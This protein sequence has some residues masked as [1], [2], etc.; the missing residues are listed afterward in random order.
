MTRFMGNYIVQRFEVAALLTH[1]FASGERVELSSDDPHDVACLFKRAL[2]HM[3]KAK[4][5]ARTLPLKPAARTLPLKPARSALAAR[6]SHPPR[7]ACS[8]PHRCA[9]ARARTQAP[10]RAPALCVQPA[11][12]RASALPMEVPQAT[13]LLPDSLFADVPLTT[14]EPSGLADRLGRCALQHAA[15]Y[16]VG[17]GMYWLRGRRPMWRARLGPMWRARLGPMWRAR[18]GPMWRARLGPTQW[19]RL[20]AT[21]SYLHAVVSH[22]RANSMG[23][24]AVAVCAAPNLVAHWPAERLAQQAPAAAAAA[25]NNR[26][27]IPETKQRRPIRPCAL[28]SHSRHSAVGTPSTESTQ[29]TSRP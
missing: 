18:L 16:R 1:R 19:R 25:N 26:A 9:R 6:G 28:P 14:S 7:P 24:R 17:L 5:A 23:A 10:A 4:P 2:R 13:P 29:S 3:T 12:G 11:R 22:E 15:A 27:V 21:L 8:P 20:S